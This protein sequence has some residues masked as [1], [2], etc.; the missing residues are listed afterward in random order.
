[1]VRQEQN[2]TELQMELEAAILDRDSLK[3]E[4]ERMTAELA[5]AQTQ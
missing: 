3:K 1:M 5:R 4:V 2:M